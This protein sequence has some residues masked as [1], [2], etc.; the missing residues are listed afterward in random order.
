MSVMVTGGTGFCGINMVK[1]LAKKGVD[2]ICLGRSAHKEDPLRDW[3]IEDVKDRV[4]LVQGDVTDPEGLKEIIKKYDVRKIVH[5]AA[6]TPDPETQRN[7]SS[8]ILSVNIAGTATLLDIARDMELDR[9]LYTS[10]AAVV[11]PNSELE[12]VDEYWALDLT[13]GLYPITK[14]ASEQLCEFY[15]KAYGVDAVSARLGWIY[16][17]MERPVD[18]RSGM[19]EVYNMVHTV[20]EGETVRT[21]DLDRYRDWTHAWDLARAMDMVLESDNLMEPMYNMT[22]GRS[23]S[24]HELVATLRE[25]MGDFDVEVVE[26]RADANVPVNSVNRRGPMSIR[27]LTHD[28][29]FEPEISLKD[30]LASYV[31]WAKKA[32][33]LFPNG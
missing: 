26:D 8:L 6:I 29:G 1:Y 30:G 17:P 28:T 27:R 22:C 32:K 2:A 13:S 16:G 9:V 23:Y 31:E 4:H 12:P 25:I 14:Y 11:A 7:R 15:G 5:T 33:E 18:A 3:F 10:S 24:G 21:N 20:L 19:S